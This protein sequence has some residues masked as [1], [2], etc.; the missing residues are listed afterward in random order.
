[1]S[2]MA[3]WDDADA[4]GDTQ[5]PRDI[6]RT[7]ALRTRLRRIEQHARRCAG[8]LDM[9]ADAM[10]DHGKSARVDAAVVAG[11]RCSM[12]RTVAYLCADVTSV[13]AE[14]VRCGLSLEVE[15][16]EL[17]GA[18]AALRMLEQ[19]VAAGVAEGELKTRVEEMQK[20][21]A[22]LGDV[23]LGLDA[24]FEES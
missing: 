17:V 21:A 24:P 3:V 8:S 12:A 4:D 23:A 7:E 1:M 11:D 2:T 9:H 10:S 15:A 14:A 6:S 20:M 22:A 16:A 19:R 13:L 18:P 5:P